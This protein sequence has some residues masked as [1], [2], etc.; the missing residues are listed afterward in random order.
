VPPRIRLRRS[1]RAADQDP[2]A[3]A[4]RRS[5]EPSSFSGRTRAFRGIMNPESSPTALRANNDFDFNTYTNTQK[6]CFQRQLIS[7]RI[8][9]YEN[10]LFSCILLISNEFNSTRKNSSG[11]KDLKPPRINTSG[12]KD[13]KSFG[14]NTSKKQGR[15][16]GGDLSFNLY[17]AI[18]SFTR[19]T[20]LPS[21]P[22]CARRH[23]LA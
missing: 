14:I 4:L 16:V 3:R 22:C 19:H 8:N 13:L 2:H 21:A 9:T 6:C 7:P 17:R 23:L 12:R 15:G 18:R 1:R 11:D 10:S 5:P 20:P